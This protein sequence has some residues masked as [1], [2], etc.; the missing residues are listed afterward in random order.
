MIYGDCT[1]ALFTVHNV[2]KHPTLWHASCEVRHW[3]HD[4]SW[5]AHILKVKVLVVI[6][7]LLLTT[8]AMA[9]TFKL[10][11]TGTGDQGQGNVT[12][13][14]ILTGTGTATPGVFDITSI[15]GTVNGLSILQIL[16]VSNP[17]IVTLSPAGAFQFNNVLYLNTN[18]QV[19]NW[20]LAFLLN[21]GFEAN[22]FSN[23]P[24]NYVFYDFNTNTGGYDTW[25]I[26]GL[27]VSQV[28]EPASLTLLGSGLLAGVGFLRRRL[29]A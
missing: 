4:T 15:N 8:A 28:P 13:N 7:L 10:T 19:D 22:N 9:D 2:H 3:H 27:Q 12:L 26:D 21:N 23:G 18:P 11:A 14:L 5:E 29:M 24:G 17:G 16:N 20:G 6:G 1:S 25:T